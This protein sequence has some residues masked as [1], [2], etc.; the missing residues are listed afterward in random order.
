LNGSLFE[1]NLTSTFWKC[2]QFFLLFCTCLYVKFVPSLLL[3]SL[4]IS[5]QVWFLLWVFFSVIEYW[6]SSIISNNMS[7]LCLSVYKNIC[8]WNVGLISRPKYI[9]ILWVNFLVKKVQTLL[10]IL[11]KISEL[12]ITC[13]PHWGNLKAWINSLI[14]I[15]RTFFIIIRS[16]FSM[17]HYLFEDNLTSILEVF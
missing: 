8:I 2:R 4:V 16:R 12:S 15:L 14:K 13:S 6:N 7:M 5:I 11:R 9:L 1:D 3:Y 10:A 17:N